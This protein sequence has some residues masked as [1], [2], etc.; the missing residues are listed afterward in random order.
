MHTVMKPIVW[1]DA[2][3]QHP[4]GGP[5]Q[6]GYPADNGYGHEEW[7]HRS[8]LIVQHEDRPMRVFHTEKISKPEI[9]FDGAPVT[10]HLYSSRGGKQVIRTTARN[11][12]SLHGDPDRRR[13]IVEALPIIESFWEDAWRLP[14]VQQQYDRLPFKKKWKK[15]EALWIPTWLC[16]VDDFFAWE[17][18][19]LID[20]PS[21]K[22]RRFGTRYTTSEKLSADSANAIEALL[23]SAEFDGRREE[24][25][26]EVINARNLSPTTKKRLIDARRGQGKFRLDLMR[27]WNDKCAVSGCGVSAVLRASH[28]KPWRDSTDDERLDP[29]NGILLAA[30]IDSLFDKFLIS[31]DEKGMMIVS[32][33]L[34][35]DELPLFPIDQNVKIALSDRMQP[36]LRYHREKMR[37]R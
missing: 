32:D 7:N 25:D 3:Y 8:E 6:G 4:T 31:F 37:N 2:G 1:N 34:S 29:N 14:F 9:V 22:G 17:T 19:I 18:P 13:S 26:I 23:P 35:K 36:Y 20:G 28:I 30:T 15:E 16:P 21:I 24:A 12:I 33:E 11:C 5:F 10:L 27:H